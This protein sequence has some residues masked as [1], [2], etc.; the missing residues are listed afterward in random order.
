M[1]RE[2]ER[3][4]QYGD[5]DIGRCQLGCNLVVL[6]AFSFVYFKVQNV[7]YELKLFVGE[8]DNFIDLQ[9]FQHFFFF[10]G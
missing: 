5:R 10:F 9:N 6:R 4:P 3:N 2:G 7:R 1:G 8:L